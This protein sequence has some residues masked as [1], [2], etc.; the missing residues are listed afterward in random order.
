[1]LGTRLWAH[2]HLP[3]ESVRTDARAAVNAPLPANPVSLAG[4]ET[5]GDPN[6]SIV[7]IVYSDFQC[8]FCGRFARET[9]PALESKYVDTG[10]VRLAFRHRPITQIHP[11]AMKASE[12]AECARRQGKFWSMHDQLFSHQ[13]DLDTPSLLARAR[14]VGLNE[15]T[16]QHCLTGEATGRVL[17]DNDAATKL[18]VFATPAF[19][20][21]IADGTGLVKVTHRLS[22]ALP[23]Q[24]FEEVLDSLVKREHG[25]N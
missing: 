22:G 5:R 25:P 6:A 23:I 16:F 9:L 15:G 18:G 7:L 21:G 20:V 12:A 24:R 14:D 3:P 11:F 2:I 17:Q 1:M 10:K 19:M 4:T 13:N 8:P